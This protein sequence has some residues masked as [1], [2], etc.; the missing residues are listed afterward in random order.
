MKKCLG[1]ELKTIYRGRTHKV[2]DLSRS[3]WK[4]L[5]KAIEIDLFD[6]DS[7]GDFIDAEDGVIDI[8]EAGEKSLRSSTLESFNKKTRSLATGILTADDGENTQELPAYS[9]AF[10]DDDDEGAGSVFPSDIFWTSD[11]DDTSMGIDD[12]D[13]EDDKMSDSDTLLED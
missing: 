2:P 10:T 4:V 6:K 8:L 11:E 3:V 7:S 13:G 12:F 9:G 1:Q 5:E